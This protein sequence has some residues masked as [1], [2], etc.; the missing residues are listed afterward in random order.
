MGRKVTHTI[1][2]TDPITLDDLRWL[3]N[4]CDGLDGKSAVSVTAR[5]EYDQ[6]DYDPAT[7][8]VHAQPVK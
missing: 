4:E 2:V 7:I 6:R 1:T 5:K 8:T 3:V